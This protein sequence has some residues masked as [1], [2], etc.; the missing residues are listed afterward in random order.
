MNLVGL[1]NFVRHFAL[2]VKYLF[3]A[4]YANAFN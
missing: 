2:L 3:M 1:L 4:L